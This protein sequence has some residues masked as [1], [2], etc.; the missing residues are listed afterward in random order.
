MA[1]HLFFDV[2]SVFLVVIRKV[3]VPGMLRDVV[4]VGEKRPDGTELRD[5]LATVH[6]SDLVLRH[7]LLA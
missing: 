7:R 1:L 6:D 3:L 2:K 4:L 5:T